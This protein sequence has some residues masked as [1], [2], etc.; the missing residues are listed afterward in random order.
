[1]FDGVDADGMIHVNWGWG[2]AG[3]GF[4][5]INDLHPNGSNNI[6][7][8]EQ[9]MVYGFKCQEKPD[10]DEIYTSLWCSISAYKFSI[11]GKILF[12][13]SGPVYNF[14]FLDFYGTFGVCIK[15]LDGDSSKD[16]FKLIHDMGDEATITFHGIGS[17]S[18]SIFLTGIKPGNYRIYLA[19]KAKNE[20]TYQP[21][22][23]PGGAM[24]YDLT[25]T[26]DGKTSLS[27]PK[28][29]TASDPV[30]SIHQTKVKPVDS[31]ITYDLQGR[32]VN[33]EPQRHGVYIRNGKKVIK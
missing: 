16:G 2:G 7:N 12:I 15:N 32:K 13:E 5:D 27:E 25:V 29:M 4:Y 19:S 26:E 14:H 11:D 30:T 18:N 21:V 10:D 33:G 24:C 6:Y 9:S 23:V 17:L 8:S 22:R 1:M 3:D 28:F 31:S 20:V